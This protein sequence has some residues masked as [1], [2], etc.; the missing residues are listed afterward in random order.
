LVV[1]LISV[2]FSY[3]VG[4]GE[5]S[6]ER[7]I[8][9]YPDSEKKYTFYLFDSDK[10]HTS[11][12]G[13]LA[14]YSTLS[15]P[16]PDGG[17]R[18][19]DVTI[20][21]PDDLSPGTHELSIVATEIASSEGS[22]GGIAS[23]RTGIKVMSLYPGKYPEFISMDASDLNINETAQISLNVVNYGKE[24]INFAYGSIVIYD[25]D[26]NTVATFNTESKSIN[27]YENTKINARLDSSRY[28]M[29]PGLY[30]AVGNFT[31]DGTTLNMTRES[32]FRVGEMKVNVIDT[33]QD[34]IVNATNKYD[35][36]VDSDWSGNINDVYAKIKTP[37]NKNIKTPN[38]DLIKSGQGQKATAQLEGY[39]ET[40]GLPLGTYDMDI[41]VYYKGLTTNKSVKVNVIDGIAPIIEKPTGIFGMGSTATAIIIAVLIIAIITIYFFAIKPRFIEKDEVLSSDYTVRDQDIRPPKL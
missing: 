1:F 29:R 13:D 6:T 31:Y 3:G 2:K 37:N 34:V 24:M 15:D 12:E 19:V 10:I 21:F 28:D 38:V 14:E 35:I 32:T 5:Y 33:T 39:W 26:N 8:L 9:F 4:I 18:N 41:T 7:R 11:I 36:M 40:N 20:R 27:S 16:D 30:R 22:V 17:P 25:E 23:V